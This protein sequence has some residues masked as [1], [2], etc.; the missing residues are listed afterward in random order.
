MA[1]QITAHSN[2]TLKRIRS[3]R[4]KKFR[5]REGLFLAEGMR[6]VTEAVDAGRIPAMLVYGEDTRG[7]PVLR[8]LAAACAAAG[9]DVIETTT[10]ILGKLA[11]KDNPQSVLG[12]FPLVE[13]PLDS[14]NRSASFAWV[15]CQS[16]KD[17]GNLGTILRT[18]DAVGAGGV[19]LLDQS[20]DPSSVE[21]VRAS[22]GALFTQD[23]VQTTAAAFFEWLR[24]GPGQLVGASLNTTHDY[25]AVTYAAPTFLFMGNEQSGLPSDVE[26]ACDEL[27]RIPMMGKAD[28]LNLASA[29]SVMIYEAWRSRSYEGA[30]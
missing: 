18:A 13:T 7:H 10:E 16:L 22:M 30:N 1:R 21:A 24:A 5:Q 28:S 11:A 23:V 17:P 4:E 25:Q 8:R 3:L 27:V 29:A 19:I 15:V 26:N 14:I 20:C 6:I 9:G 12:V 2:E